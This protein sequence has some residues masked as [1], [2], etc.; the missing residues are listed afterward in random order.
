M[1]PAPEQRF[2]LHQVRPQHV[3]GRR[4]LHLLRHQDAPLPLAAQAA[5]AKQPEAKPA[6]APK[7]PGPAPKQAAPAAKKPESKPAAA[8][9]TAA[10]PK[11]AAARPP[12]ATRALAVVRPRCPRQPRPPHTHSEGRMNEHSGRGSLDGVP[13]GVAGLEKLWMPDNFSSDPSASP[14]RT[15]TTTACATAVLPRLCE[16]HDLGAGLLRL[17]QRASALLPQLHHVAADEGH[18]DARR[19]VR[20]APRPV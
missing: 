12:A 7:Q 14:S 18:H 1:P 6:A 17:R 16:T 5:P 4:L 19:C 9:K 15:A 11:S 13:S 2:Q 3:R 10:V 8:K 20:A